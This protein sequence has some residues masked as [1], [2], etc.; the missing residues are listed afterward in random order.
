MQKWGRMYTGDVIYVQIQ[1]AP[2]MLVVSMTM[3]A[4]QDHRLDV[5]DSNTAA[6][7]QPLASGLTV[8][9]NPINSGV[10]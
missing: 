2:D 3:F 1:A 9:Y 8:S 7:L 5:S 10:C 6:V 4:P